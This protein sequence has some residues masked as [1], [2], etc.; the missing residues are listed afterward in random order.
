MHSDNDD[1]NLMDKVF[2]DHK[3]TKGV[4]GYASFHFMPEGSFINN[5]NIPV[6]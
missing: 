2:V 6:E 3:F 1:F 5:V 4:K